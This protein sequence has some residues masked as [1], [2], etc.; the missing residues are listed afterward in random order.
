MPTVHIYGDGCMETYI[1][2]VCRLNNLSVLQITTRLSD[3]NQ[4]MLLAGMVDEQCA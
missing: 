1:K 4:L 2:L 3:T